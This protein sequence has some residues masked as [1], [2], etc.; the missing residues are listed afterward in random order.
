MEA[1]GRRM[2]CCVFAWLG[3]ERIGWK[4]DVS[5][6]KRKSGKSSWLAANRMQVETYLAAM[7]A[8]AAA[9]CLSWSGCGLAR[10]MRPCHH[11]IQSQLRMI[12]HRVTEVRNDNAARS[13]CGLGDSVTLV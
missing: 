4:F 1:V 9:V 2:D 5:G 11:R 13:F 3:R 10:V 7:S 6:K 8:F 12:H